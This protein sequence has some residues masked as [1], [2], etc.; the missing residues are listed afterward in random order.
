MNGFSRKK[1]GTLTLGEKLKKL[2]ADRRISLSEVARSTR[3]QIKYLESLEEGNYGALPADVYVRGFLKNYADFLGVD[4]SILIRIYDREKG[5]KKNI[6]DKISPRKEPLFRAV[7]VN[8]FTL[9]PKRIAGALAGALLLAVVVL[10]Y[11]EVGSFSNSPKLVILSPENNWE[12]SERTIELE[13]VAEKD[14][15]V[16]INAQPIVVSE[17]GDFRE[18]LNLQEGLNNIEVRSINRFNKETARQLTV[19]LKKP[20]EGGENSSQSS[21]KN[22]K[23]TWSLEIKVDPGPVWLKVE[24]DG[25]LVFTG[26]MLSGPTQIFE[27]KEEFKVSSGKG[28]ATWIK[29]TGEEFRKLSEEPGAVKD[30]VLEK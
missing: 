11:L 30:L 21:E 26:N 29:L 19:Y 1:I 7:N 13:G 3:I 4:E 10:L 5:I 18:S 8:F 16:F 25:E 15:K 22:E 20:E 14:A 23:E 12:T 17:N 2:R 24:A 9:T 27:G 28:E 6:E